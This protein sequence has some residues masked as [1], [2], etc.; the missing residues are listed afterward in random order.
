MSETNYLLPESM[1]KHILWLIPIQVSCLLSGRPLG[2][3][4]SFASSEDDV[5]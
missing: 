1:S 3:H 5:P 4:P 2:Y